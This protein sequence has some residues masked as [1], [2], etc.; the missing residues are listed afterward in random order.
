ME[1]ASLQLLDREAS[2]ALAGSLAPE[3]AEEISALLNKPVAVFDEW[4]ASLGL[5]TA[6]R[7]VFKGAKEILGIPVAKPLPKRT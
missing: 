4:A 7:D 6:A 3:L 1:C 2:I 5:A